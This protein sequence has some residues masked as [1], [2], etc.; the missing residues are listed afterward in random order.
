MHI[1]LANAQRI[2][3][4]DE[5]PKGHPLSP[6]ITF[7]YSSQGNLSDNLATLT[8]HGFLQLGLQKLVYSFPNN[9]LVLTGFLWR[10]EVSRILNLLR[11]LDP[12][13]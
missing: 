10:R 2:Q 8:L 7:V 1:N 12:F 6:Q 9:L 3:Y 4:P 11:A 13:P 5:V